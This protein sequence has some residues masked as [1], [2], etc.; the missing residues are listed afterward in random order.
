MQQ[1][2]DRAQREY[3]QSKVELDIFL[4]HQNYD[5]FLKRLRALKEHK[6]AK[7]KSPSPSSPNIASAPTLKAKQTVTLSKDLPLIQ[8]QHQKKEQMQK[9]KK[10][11]NS[12]E[13]YDDIDS[14]KPSGGLNDDFF[15]DLDD[16]KV[17]M[18]KNESDKESETEIE[19]NGHSSDDITKQKLSNGHSMKTKQKY[20]RMPDMKMNQKQSLMKLTSAQIES[21]E[22]EEYDDE[23]LV[24]APSEPIIRKIIKSP[25]KIAQAPKIEIIDKMTI[26]SV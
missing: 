9:K 8:E 14:F 18:N 1:E 3:E 24:F 26:T 17:A 21:S 12:K 16:A 10:E 20:D 15:A 13:K 4:N 2:L 25:P 22:S 5:E 7:H 11:L 23:P 6:N 19:M